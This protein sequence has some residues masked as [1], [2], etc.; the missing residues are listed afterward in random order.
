MPW[1]AFVQTC[2]HDFYGTAIF[3]KEGLRPMKTVRISMLAL[4]VIG[5]APAS[6]CAH[7]ILGPAA[8]LCS[9]EGVP[10][11]LVRVGGLQSRI[12]KVRVRTFGGSPDSY[13]DKKRALKR[14]EVPVPAS[15]PI[16]ICMPVP[17]PG[18]YAVDVRHDVNNN[19]KTDRADG[20]GVSG[21]PKVSLLDVI[22]KR[23]PPAKQVQVSVGS[24]T[25]VVPI[26]VRYF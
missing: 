5:L 26:Q 8:P 24:G 12:G 25:T 17:G 3:R 15:G 10:S 11:I 18:V 2:C 21:N 6:L 1:R 23:K 13:F 14:I 7:T 9:S 20:G 22:F 4:S 19:G 16:D